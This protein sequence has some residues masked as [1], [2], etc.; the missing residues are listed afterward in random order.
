MILSHLLNVLDIPPHL[1]QNLLPIF[2]LLKDPY[3][4]FAEIFLNYFPFQ[5]HVRRSR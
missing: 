4:I 1:K 5:T 2:R 3:K